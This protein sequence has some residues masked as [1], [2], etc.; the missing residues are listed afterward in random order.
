MAVAPTMRVEVCPGHPQ[1]IRGAVLSRV[2]LRALDTPEPAA[3]LAWLSAHRTSLECDQP[4]GLDLARAATWWAGQLADSAAGSGPLSR[5]SAM[6]AQVL[7]AAGLIEQDIRFGALFAAW[8]DPLRSR[9]PCVGLLGWLL[10]DRGSERD[11][12]TA[13]CHE[14]VAGGLAVV[15][16]P[17]DPRAE[18]VLRVPVPVWDLVETGQ[19]QLGSLPPAI[20]LRPRES[21][22]ALEDLVVDEASAA[23]VRQLPAMVT[24]GALTSIVVRGMQGAGRTTVLGAVASALDLDLLVH[25]GPPGGTD[26]HLFTALTRL[27]D[28]LP[29]VRVDP[30]PGETVS[31]PRV[32]GTAG[33]LGIVLGRSG[34]VSGTSLEQAVT[35]ALGPCRS[36]DRR[37]M[38]RRSGIDARNSALGDIVDRFLLAPAAIHRSAPLARAAAHAAGRKSVGVDDV[39]TATRTLGRQGLESLATPLDPLPSLAAPVLTPSASE[40][41]DTLIRRC[42]HRERLVEAAEGV[43]GGLNRGVRALFTGPSGT[44]KTLAARHLAAVLH[45]DLYR[46]DLA[47]VVNKYIGE[48]ERNLETVL[49]RAEEVDV[50][51][52][53]DEGDALM[54]RRTDVSNANDR[55]ANLETNF[56]LQRL[57]TFEGIVIITTNAGSRIDPAFLRRIDVTVDFVPPD[58][59]QRWQIWS[60]HLSP[61][62]TVD[63]AL[64]MEVARRCAL[65]GGQIRNAALHAALL[66]IDREEPVADRDLLAALRR[67]Y[68]RTGGSYPLSGVEHAWT[69]QQT[70]PW[71]GGSRR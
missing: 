59:D 69:G 31:L 27:A 50:V 28:V 68:R 10:A 7:V 16:N 13:A 65:T 53:L 42:R 29:V 66:A 19:L 3:S 57:E 14:L 58:A 4:P 44:G 6:A 15:E 62:S 60:A 67:E 41:L 70:E 45:L 9:R 48:T 11:V 38:W 33:A 30:G 22:P 71:A 5:V 36:D 35:L 34:G 17:D 24:G 51:L 54:A 18:W 49:A 26:W 23:V 63:P 52:L 20:S 12:V 21:F 64:V 8:Q 37:V 1:R 32:S 39:Q 40:E 61:E 46:V 55:Y 25:H 2:L 43:A 56:L 47:A